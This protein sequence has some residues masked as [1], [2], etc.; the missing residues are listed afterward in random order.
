MQGG[1]TYGQCTVH[2]RVGSPH[3]VLG[4]D[5]FAQF[6]TLCSAYNLEEARR[7]S[8]LWHGASPAK[9]RASSMPSC[10]HGLHLRR[11]TNCHKLSESV[12]HASSGASQGHQRWPP[13]H[14]ESW[15]TTS[16]HMLPAA[17]QYRQRVA[18]RQAWT[19]H[20]ASI[21]VYARS[22]TGLPSQ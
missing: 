9:T 2:R 7:V 14:A 4:S 16:T 15:S 13:T 17:A 5:Q 12:Y 11:S 18:A 21:L 20:P 19:R 10:A 6:L 1:T 8:S 3:R 22:P